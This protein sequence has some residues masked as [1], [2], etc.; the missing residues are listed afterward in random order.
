MGVLY[1]A[2][3][4]IPVHKPHDLRVVIAGA[5]DNEP[6]PLPFIPIPKKASRLLQLC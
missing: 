1:V 3:E 4:H 2:Y 5:G 6:V